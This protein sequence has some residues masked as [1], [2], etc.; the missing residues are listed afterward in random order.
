MADDAVCGSYTKERY[1][2]ILSLCCILKLYCIIVGVINCLEYPYAKREEDMS[3]CSGAEICLVFCD[4]GFY[5]LI[6]SPPAFFYH[7]KL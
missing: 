3:N 4:I 2:L 6:L 1:Q 5:L 7:S